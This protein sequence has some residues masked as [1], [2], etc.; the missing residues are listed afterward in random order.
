MKNVIV[1]PDKTVDSAKMY[2]GIEYKFVSSAF[3]TGSLYGRYAPGGTVRL[4]GGDRL[5][6]CSRKNSSMEN[7]K[8]PKTCLRQEPQKTK[9]L[10]PP[11]RIRTEPIHLRLD[12]TGTEC[13]TPK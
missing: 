3:S 2:V 11:A 13:R 7:E 8:M 10:A 5:C 6:R 12:L 4:Y 9:T 1:K